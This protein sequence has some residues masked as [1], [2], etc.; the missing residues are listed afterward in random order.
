MG[1]WQ[2]LPL[3]T[4]KPLNWSSPK[5][6]YVIKSWIST[7]VLNLVIT[8]PLTITQVV[9]FPCMCEIAHQNVYSASFMGSSNQRFRWWA[10][11]RIIRQN[12][13]PKRPKLDGPAYEYA[14]NKMTG[15]HVR[16]KI[17][18]RRAVWRPL[19]ITFIMIC[20]SIWSSRFTRH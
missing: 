2:I 9:S 8:I 17:I 1:K 14:Q 18:S 19:R 5:V 15:V 12:I 3:A 10:Y 7:Q 16:R 6:A 13:W 20:V 11:G 4:P